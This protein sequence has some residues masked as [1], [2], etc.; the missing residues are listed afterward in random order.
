[1]KK[2]DIVIA[3]CRGDATRLA[4]LERA[5]AIALELDISATPEVI[6]GFVN[7]VLEF[8]LVKS[9]AGVN[10]LVNNAGYAAFGAAE[11]IT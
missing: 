2:G 1:L 3:T 6:Q 9:N 11:E 5:G 8:P 7:T 10:M 4:D